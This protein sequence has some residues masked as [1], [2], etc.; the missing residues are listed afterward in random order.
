MRTIPN[1]WC[2]AHISVK[3]V[4]ELHSFSIPS[5]SGLG[6]AQVTLKRKILHETVLFVLTTVQVQVQVEIVS[7][8]IVSSISHK[9][10]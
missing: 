7:A 3:Q 9:I 2:D 10:R 5:V 1:L 6:H 4:V 8:E